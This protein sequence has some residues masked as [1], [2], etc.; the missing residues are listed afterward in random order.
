M[1]KRQVKSQIAEA[2]GFNAKKIVLLEA[3]ESNGV[4]D[5]VMF[6]VCGIEYSTDFVYLEILNQ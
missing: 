6:E 1:N 5:Y 3:G 4:L 2:Y